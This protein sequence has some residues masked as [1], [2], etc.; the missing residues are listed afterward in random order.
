MTVQTLLYINDTSPS[1]LT[2]SDVDGYPPVNY[3]VK[4]SKDGQTFLRTEY[5]LQDQVN[6]TSTENPTS[7]N[8]AGLLTFSDG[9]TFNTNTRVYTFASG[10]NRFQTSNLGPI[11]NQEVD[12]NITS[13]S[14]YVDDDNHIVYLSK[15]TKVVGNNGVV[16]ST[17]SSNPGQVTLEIDPDYMPTLPSDLTGQTLSISGDSTMHQTTMTT[18]IVDNIR[19]NRTYTKA[20]LAQLPKGTIVRLASG[21]I[22]A[23][24]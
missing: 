23:N 6:P 5:T 9:D 7:S 22:K 16:A 17:N 14:S 19:L 21:E 3:K 4:I 13:D 2:F 24:L 12:V 15:L 1:S 20:E 8:G 10:I 18:A 11:D